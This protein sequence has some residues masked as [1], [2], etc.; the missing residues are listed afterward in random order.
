MEVI[1]EERLYSDKHIM[2]RL[3]KYS[4]PHYKSFIAA[5][6]L[7]LVPIGAELVTPLLLGKVVSILKA[8]NIE[9]NKIIYII[10]CYCVII[11]SSSISGYF[12]TIILQKTGQNIIYTVREEIFEHIEKL[13]ANQIN[14][15]PV[16][17]LVTRVTNDTNNLNELYTSVIISLLKS[18][19][20]LI[21]VVIMMF[22]VNVQITLYILISAPFVFGLSL[23]FRKLS[24]RAY[25]QVR[26][27]IT[28]V[29]TF[30][31]ENISGIKITQ[32]FNQEEK[33]FNE[34]CSKNNNL[35]KSQLNQIFIFSIFRPAIYG[36][37]ILTIILLLYFGSMNNLSGGVITAEII[38][39]F[40]QYVR[41]FFNPLQELAD[42]FNVLQSAFAS[43]EKIFSLL[44][45]A[46]EIID[47]PD[48]I[49]LEDF[50]GEIEFKDVWFSYIPDEWVL[51]GVSF[52]V[53]PN[54]T[55]AFVGATG[56]GK[57]TIL[58][59]IVRNY[60]IQKGQILID[61][62][63]IKTYTIASI[64]RNIGQ[65]LQDVFLFSGS[66]LSN[67]QLKD[68]TISL[69]DVKK[70][71]KYVNADKFIERLP[72]QYEEVVRER[73]NNFSS[74]QRQ[75]ISFARTIVH[76]PKLMILDEATANIDTETEA[77]IQDSLEK[78]M[79]IGTMLIVA[80]RLSTI[81][82]SDN[83]IVLSKGK[84]IESGTHQE[85]L[86]NKKHYYNLYRLQYEHSQKND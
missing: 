48:A 77:L 44:D 49:E 4:K 1:K 7:M 20:T 79:S 78:M 82:H 35:K 52:K 46:P 60:D 51:K 27:N 55:V 39:I 41:S 18:S 3:L 8:D 85:L 16:G 66:I 63:D 72:N 45:T 68:D 47:S 42:Q 14:N 80:H 33:K 53:L 34:F 69:E 76:K 81:Q 6:L 29:N 11:V 21:G 71:T 59:L 75:L 9:F 40:Y 73:G 37:Y 13:S 26:N 36:L 32:T 65:M 23:L 19:L 64:R 84:I 67:I 24:R 58:S 62:K 10:I 83:I 56:S 38:V 17:K 22:I 2:S 86:K 57:T 25:R 5:F 31:S 30:L 28:D 43:S 70:A 61:G 54:Q 15:L 74:G 50:K 12:H